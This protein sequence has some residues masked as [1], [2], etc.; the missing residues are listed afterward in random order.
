MEMG[1]ESENVSKEHV[2]QNWDCLK[3]LNLSHCGEEDKPLIQPQ[4]QCRGLAFKHTDNST[5]NGTFLKKKKTAMIA[6]LFKR[7]VNE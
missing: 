3:K 5:E 1:L 4:I 2:M 7:P 6:V